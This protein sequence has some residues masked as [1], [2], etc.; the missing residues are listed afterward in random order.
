MKTQTKSDKGNNAAGDNKFIT[1]LVLGAVSAGVLALLLLR[2]HIPGRPAEI[3]RDQVHAKVARWIVPDAPTPIPLGAI[4]PVSREITTAE[5][6]PRPL[7]SRYRPRADDEWQG[8]LVDLAVKP[9]C[10]SPTPCGLARACVNG[11]CVACERDPD[12]EPGEGCVLDHCIRQENIRCRGH[13]SCDDGEVCILSGYSSDARGNAQ[14]LSQCIPSTGGKEKPTINSP[15][16]P[17]PRK[18]VFDDERERARAGIP[19]LIHK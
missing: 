18:V 19:G 11:Q 4:A 13:R 17:D 10:E 14:M 1:K 6:F 12:C 5:M 7:P 8:M 3:S 9:P 16:P 2:S 15:Q